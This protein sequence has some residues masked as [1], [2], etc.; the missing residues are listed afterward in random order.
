MDKKN[1][2]NITGKVLKF[3]YAYAET[4]HG[5]NSAIEAGYKESRARIQA[6]ELLARPEVNEKINELKVA[7]H[8]KRIVSYEEACVVVSDILKDEAT[9]RTTDRL[10]A[11]NL[12][13]KMRG[14]HEAKPPETKP[15]EIKITYDK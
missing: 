1:N 8:D 13:G 15:I 6:S 2:F 7:V 12:L 9:V 3:C 4:L 5:K 14:W 10:A 11:T